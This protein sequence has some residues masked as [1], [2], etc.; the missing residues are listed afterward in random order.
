MNAG[1][2]RLCVFPIY[3]CKKINP[4]ATNQFNNLDLDC[5]PINKIF[6][7]MTT[8]SASVTC[9][10]CGVSLT[11]DPSDFDRHPCPSCGSSMRTISLSLV[12]TVQSVIVE[13]LKGVVKDTT[14]SGKKKVRYSFVSGHDWSYKLSR[15]VL[16]ERIID[17]DNNRYMEKVVDPVTGDVLRNAEEP[18]KQHQGHGTAKFKTAPKGASDDSNSPPHPSP[19][20]PN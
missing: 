7:A 5:T 4:Q 17:K 1:P 18:L 13:E 3:G 9:T 14:R 12:D 16:K 6:S 15:Y 20:L 10:D 11:Q 2:H 8:E 19:S